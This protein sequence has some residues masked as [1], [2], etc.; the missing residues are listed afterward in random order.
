MD[1]AAATTAYATELV[2]IGM[3][4]AEADKKAAS[5]VAAVVAGMTQDKAAVVGG[6]DLLKDRVGK[7]LQTDKR[8]DRANEALD[9]AESSKNAFDKMNPEVNLFVQESLA[10]AP[11]LVM[12]GEEFDLARQTAEGDQANINRILIAPN[13]P[14]SVPAGDLVSDFIPQIIRQL[15]RFAWLAVLVSLTVSGVMMVMAHDEDEKITK[16]KSMIFYSLI[17]FAFI[18]LA[19]ALV[20]AV[21][22]IDF[23]NF[24]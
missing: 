2:S 24:V 5:D 12:P 17:G 1:R 15:F 7:L 22:N 14:G 13:Q 6:F 19:F 23:F 16:A 18:A 4:K 9:A 20:K 21:T 3:D 8:K 10:G 11:P